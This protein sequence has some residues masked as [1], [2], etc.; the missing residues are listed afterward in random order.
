LAKLVRTELQ[1]EK[2]W[3]KAERRSLA[4]Q[5]EALARTA[6][7]RV[8]AADALQARHDE[9]RAAGEPL[10]TA[11]CSPPTRLTE[12]VPIREAGGYGTPRA[13]P[14]AVANQMQSSQMNQ[15]GGP[16]SWSR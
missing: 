12:E 5:A 11:T 16:G 4:E 13:A 6:A 14:E 15:R 9:M 8:R 10:R 2:D 3:W 7:Q 1:A